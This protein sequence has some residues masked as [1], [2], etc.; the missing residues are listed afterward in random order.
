MMCSRIMF[1]RSRMAD[2]C[3]LWTHGNS[4][5]L[6]RPLLQI[7]CEVCK[8]QARSRKE[9]AAQMLA[10]DSRQEGALSVHRNGKSNKS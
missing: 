2:P 9:H 1:T 4:L 5:Q 6:V 7:C 8:P 3:S 10:A